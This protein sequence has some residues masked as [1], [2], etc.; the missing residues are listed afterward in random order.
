[1]ESYP[2]YSPVRIREALTARG[3]APRKKLGQNFLIDR[4][5]AERCAEVVAS[6]SGTQKSVVEIGPGL[7]AVTHLLLEKGVTVH[8]V[9]IDPVLSAV[10]RGMWGEHPLFKLTEGDA[11]DFLQ[12]I[13]PGA[14]ACICGNIPYY[15][16]TDLLLLALKL[17]PRHVVFLV[18]HDFARRIL[19]ANSESSLCVFVRNMAVVREEI[20]MS[21]TGFFPAPGVDSSLIVLD[22]Y[23]TGP[24]SNPLVLEKL[25]RA[26]FLAR[27]KKLSNS[28]KHTP[29]ESL[30]CPLERLLEGAAAVGI[31]LTH[32]AEECAPEFYFALANWID[33]TR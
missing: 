31:D 33:G 14:F 9:E 23:D 5:Y 21:A 27:R 6:L 26:S 24:K 4:N 2:F 18:Q 22:L 29:S 30:P 13:E 25:L 32:R 8:G 3:A 19:A 20:R 12:T 10:L 28:W 17:R 7:G 11:R 16:T 15:I 1:M